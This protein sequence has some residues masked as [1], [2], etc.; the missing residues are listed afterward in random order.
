MIDTLL[1]QYD[2]SEIHARKINASVKETYANLRQLDFRGSLISRFLFK[3][4]GLNTKNMSFDKMV[5]RG[6]FFTIYEKENQEWIVGLLAESFTMPSLLKPDQ[7]FRDW[8]PH[9][10]VKIA[11]NFLLKP[12]TKETVEVS[13]ETRIQCLS[14]KSKFI[15]T[16]YWMFVRLFSGLSRLEMYVY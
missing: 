2:F 12:V 14:S 11:W 10:G 9:R 7:D 13:T 6:S 16:I 15:F 1:P 8:N 3:L 5:N 4:R